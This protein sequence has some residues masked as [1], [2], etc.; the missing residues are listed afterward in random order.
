[1]EQKLAE[2]RSRRQTEHV[3]KRDQCAGPQ[4]KPTPGTDTSTT[5]S[6]VKEE[7]SENIRASTESSPSQVG[8]CLTVTS[9]EDG[10]LKL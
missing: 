5:E 9:V 8:P 6:Q 1:M 3:P 10:F 2:F 7:K 4:P